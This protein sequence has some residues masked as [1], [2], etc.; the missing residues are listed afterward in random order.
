[1]IYSWY[2]AFILG[3]KW[4]MSTPETFSPRGIRQHCTLLYLA[5]QFC[6]IF[7]HRC[8]RCLWARW[9]VLATDILHDGL[10]DSCQEPASEIMFHTWRRQ[11]LRR[12]QWKPSS[13]SLNS[14]K[15]PTFQTSRDEDESDSEAVSVSYTTNERLQWD[16]SKRVTQCSTT[17]HRTRTSLV[18]LF[19]DLSA[20]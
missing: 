3:M 4:S 12:K 7:T 8:S 5:K 6:S 20:N 13:F 14:M 1:M 9:L 16:I 15:L 2:S 18:W 19:R 17:A 10:E 11:Q